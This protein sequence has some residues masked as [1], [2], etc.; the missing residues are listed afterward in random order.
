M[1][2]DTNEILWHKC[3]LDAALLLLLH[4]TSGLQFCKYRVLLITNVYI[5]FIIM[6]HIVIYF[7]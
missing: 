2:S 1:P 7:V 6:V 5:V 3:V 4:K